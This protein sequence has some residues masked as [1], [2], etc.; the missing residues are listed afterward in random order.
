MLILTLDFSKCRN[1]EL[2]DSQLMVHTIELKPFTRVKVCE[3]KS[4]NPTLLWS[5]S[6]SFSL[7][8]NPPDEISLQRLCAEEAENLDFLIQKAKSLNFSCDRVISRIDEVTAAN[9]ISYIDPE[10]P[11]TLSSLFSP[12][13]LHTTST[14]DQLLTWKRPN[15]GFYER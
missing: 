7:L 5:L 9:D 3:I 8:L 10:F 4:V 13:D 2:V 15:K 1:M 11:P 6:P 14:L 12:S